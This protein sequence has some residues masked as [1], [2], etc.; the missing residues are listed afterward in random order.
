MP[1]TV[2]RIGPLFVLALALGVIGDLASC[3]SMRIATLWIPLLAGCHYVAVVLAAIGFGPKIGLA[4]AIL[5]S[6]AHV[7]VGVIACGQSIL[8]Q[9]EVAAFII[10]GII[11]GSVAARPQTGAGTSLEAGVSQDNRDEKLP[12]ISPGF[13]KTARNP[14]SAIESAGYLLEDPQLSNETQRELASIILRECRR[15]DVLIS[16]LDFIQPRSPAYR[17]V[18]LSSLLDEVV[19]LA[20]PATTAASITLRKEP[21]SAV[22][23]M[24]DSCLIIQAILNLI[25]NAIPIAGSGASLVLSAETDN[26]QVVIHVSHRNPGDL[27]RLQIAM[28]KEAEGSPYGHRRGGKAENQILMNGA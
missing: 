5:V 18:D 12:H 25:T 16:T 23:L 13:V 6:T 1:P 10:V 15:L 20:E 3:T 26:D 8:Q 9:G 7:L 22:R 28:A 21:G 11:A 17:A 27:G 4:A 19:Q 24:C 2:A 14:L